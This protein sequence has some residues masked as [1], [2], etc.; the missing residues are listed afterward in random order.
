M[1]SAIALA[2]FDQPL[3]FCFG[4]VLAGAHVGVP[5]ATRG[6]DFPYLVS[7]DTIFKG[8]F[9]IGFNAPFQLLSV[10]NTE[11]L[12]AH[13]WSFIGQNLRSR[14]VDDPKYPGAR[15]N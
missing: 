9:A 1:R 6:C 2:A 15:D 11:S 12:H 4:Q 10:V 3:D 13:F 14:M 7:G 8:G 5:G